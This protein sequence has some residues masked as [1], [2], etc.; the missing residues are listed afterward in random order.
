[1]IQS[2]TLKNVHLKYNLRRGEGGRGGGGRG[3]GA[4]ITLLEGGGHY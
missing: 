3:G 4:N 2:I 1:M